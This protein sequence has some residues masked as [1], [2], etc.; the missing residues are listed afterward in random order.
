MD[1]QDTVSPDSLPY[2]VVDT[3]PR[4]RRHEGRLAQG[5]RGAPANF[6]PTHLSVIILS[7]PSQ[8]KVAVRSPRWW[9]S[10]SIPVIPLSGKAG[11]PI[12]SS[13]GRRWYGVLTTISGA[14][15]KGRLG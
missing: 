15:D 5:V 11:C 3:T 1:I 9:V 2:L 4:L 13:F 8:E 10:A 6:E 14:K 12:L 7:T